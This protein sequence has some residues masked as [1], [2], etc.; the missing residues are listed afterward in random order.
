MVRVV[1]NL[2]G[3]DDFIICERDNGL[4]EGRLLVPQQQVRSA[5]LV[6]ALLGCR[7]TG[8]FDLL[9][10]MVKKAFAL[11]AQIHATRE[12]VFIS[13]GSAMGGLYSRRRQ[14]K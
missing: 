11:A 13:L 8:R 5:Q 9:A 14:I 4:D 10:V 3:L 12:Q 6:S 2:I 1:L 7:E